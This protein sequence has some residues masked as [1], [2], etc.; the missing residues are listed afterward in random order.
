MSESIISDLGD[1]PDQIVCHESQIEPQLE[2]IKRN[3]SSNFMGTFTSSGKVS[4]KPSLIS[5][6]ARSKLEIPNVVKKANFI[7]AS[8]KLMNLMTQSQLDHLKI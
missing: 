3:S 4:L 8:S 7:L 5:A 2:T 1:K 6:P